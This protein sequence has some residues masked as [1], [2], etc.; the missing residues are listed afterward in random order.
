MKMGAYGQR[1]MVGRLV[2]ACMQALFCLVLLFWAL[3]A[4]AYADEAPDAWLPFT[5]GDKTGWVSP[6]G[7]VKIAP[8]FTAYAK[9]GPN[10]MPQW[11]NGITAVQGDNGWGL[12]NSQGEWVFPA[13]LQDIIVP[14]QAGLWAAKMNNKWGYVNAQGQWVLQPQYAFAWP[15]LADA[16]A[17]VDDGTATFYVDTAGKKHANQSVAEYSPLPSN[18]FFPA[19][20]NR[21]TQKVRYF[22]SV[23]TVTDSS[24]SHPTSNSFVDKSGTVHFAQRFTEVT[25][26]GENGL[27]RALDLKT[28]KWGM[29]NTAGE[30]V[31]KPEY[32]SLYTLSSGNVAQYTLASNGKVGLLNKNGNIIIKPMYDGVTPYGRVKIKNSYGLVND[33]GEF[34]VKAMMEE[35]EPFSKDFFLVK[36]QGKYGLITIQGQWKIP[37]FFQ[38]LRPCAESMAR[39]QYEGKWGFVSDQGAWAISPMFEMAETFS[40]GVAAVQKEGKW[41]YITPQGNWKVP[42]QFTKAEKA[43]GGIATIEVLGEPGFVLL[44]QGL[45]FYEAKVCGQSV[46]KSDAHV[47]VWPPSDTV[48]KACAGQYDKSPVLRRL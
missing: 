4:K 5:L 37:L 35:L 48:Q 11:V 21:Q 31:V 29:I 34:I 7:A 19:F 28:N 18:G 20:Y 22:P 44:Q 1:A 36:Q 33:Q 26:F 23:A 14:A 3:C 24:P 41:G 25:G 10:N 38:D 32:L 47:I 27:A 8:L 30:W 2:P 42:P 16:R 43:T 40:S 9:Q 17:L 15:F 12:I 6:Q 45:V 39:A 46:L 13:T